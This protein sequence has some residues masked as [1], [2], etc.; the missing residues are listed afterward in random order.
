MLKKLV[1]GLVFLVACFVGVQAFTLDGVP[2]LVFGLML[3][4]DTVY[5]P[6]YTDAG[7]RSIEV[8]MTRSEV[9]A[10]VGPPQKV[11]TIDSSDV[12]D[13]GARWSY[14]PGDTHYRERTL[15]FHKG[16]VVEKHTGYYVD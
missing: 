4:E 13:E 11:W 5:T 10:I 14:S 12:V 3:Q 9:E 2:G 6:G 8:G 1:V 7:F 15:L 16:V